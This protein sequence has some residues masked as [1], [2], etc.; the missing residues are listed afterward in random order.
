M[1]MIMVIQINRRNNKWNKRRRNKKINK[2]IWLWNPA[3]IC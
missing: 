2:K 1:Q 3:Q